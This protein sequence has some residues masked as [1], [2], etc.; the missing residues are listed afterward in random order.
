MKDKFCIAEIFPF[1]RY[2]VCP[3]TNLI[4]GITY[5]RKKSA[6]TFFSEAQRDLPRC[7]C[8]L[9]KRKGFFGRDV[10]VIGHYAGIPF[11]FGQDAGRQ[12]GVA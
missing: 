1:W 4:P 9:L 10:V 3:E 12:K 8:Y 11:R 2:A 7:G 6:E 5:Y